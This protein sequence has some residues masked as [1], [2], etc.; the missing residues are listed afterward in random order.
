MPFTVGW[1]RS[2]LE[3]LA[4]IWINAPSRQA[5][6]NA[7]RRIDILLRVS[8]MSVGQPLGLNRRL[9]V[10]P[11]QVVYRVLPDDCLVRVLRVK[12]VG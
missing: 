1:I 4:R 10:G 5:I 9:T 8:S 2:A 3:E 7:S 6:N 12:F 11:L